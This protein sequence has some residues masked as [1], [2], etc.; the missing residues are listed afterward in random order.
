MS[1]KTDVYG[2]FKSHF[3][4]IRLVRL[5]AGCLFMA[6][7]SKE[8]CGEVDTSITLDPTIAL[9]YNKHLLYST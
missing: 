4:R 3:R 9:P 6:M 8:C 5:Y 7:V 1:Y 2:C